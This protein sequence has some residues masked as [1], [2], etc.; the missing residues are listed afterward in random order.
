MDIRDKV[1]LVGGIGCSGWIPVYIDVDTLHV[2]HGRAIPFASG[3]K[4]SDPSRKVIVFT[5][6]GDCL[7]IGGNHFIHGARRNIDITVIMV[8]NQIYGM[9]GGQVAPTTPSHGKTKTSPYGNP[10]IPFDGC[11]LAKAAGA[12]FVARWTTAHPRQLSKTIAEAI[13][14]E[15]F[16]FIE[17]LTQCPTQA[18]RVI[19]GVADPA[20]L[21]DML[22]ANTINVNAAKNK[23]IEELTG[24]ILIGNLYH[25][26]ERLE[27]ASNYYKKISKLAASC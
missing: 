3:L 14:H 21:L 15:G 9:T 24:K 27:F 20:Q 25:D 8:H 5:G 19:Y 10:E 4:M 1:A 12:T 22:K 2:L 18:G 23:S 16:S 17:V 26:D 7:G 13:D 6:D 11:A